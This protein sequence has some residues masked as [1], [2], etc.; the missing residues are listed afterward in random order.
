MSNKNKQN[1]RPGPNPRP[2]PLTEEKG[3]TI[4][5]PPRQVKPS[6]K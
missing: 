4:S 3:R 2:R 1:P 6:K 5:K